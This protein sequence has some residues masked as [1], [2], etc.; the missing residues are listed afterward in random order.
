MRAGFI[1]ACPPAAAVGA[2]AL[3]AAEDVVVLTTSMDL[4]FAQARSGQDADLGHHILSSHRSAEFGRRYG[5]LIKEW[6]MLQ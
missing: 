1:A 4:R 3:E 2:A 6:R 5:V